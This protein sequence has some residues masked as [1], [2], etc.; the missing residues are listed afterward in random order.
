MNENSTDTDTK[1][2]AEQD[3]NISYIRFDE[4]STLSTCSSIVLSSCS[5]D[6]ENAVKHSAPT[7]RWKRQKII[8]NKQ[9]NT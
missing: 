1:S 2:T 5:S 4:N 7:L 9:H 3:G 8:N 6:D